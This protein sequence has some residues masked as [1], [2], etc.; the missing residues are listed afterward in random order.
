MS[1]TP[2][3]S[4]LFGLQLEN[5]FTY[6]GDNDNNKSCNSMFPNLKSLYIYRCDQLQFILPRHSAGDLLLLESIIIANCV[7]L[8]HI[9]GQHQDV[10]LASLKSL[11]LNDLPNFIDIFPESYDSMPLSIKGPSNSNSKVQTQLE[12]IKS[13]V[14]SWSHICCRRYKLKGPT[15]TEISLVSDGQP[16]DLSISLVTSSHI[17]MS[18]AI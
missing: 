12:P 2:R 9:F 17:F 10:Q 11:E 14:F 8:K 5:I 3:P 18:G 16:K 4:L 13:N 15:S 6:D 7:K 1:F